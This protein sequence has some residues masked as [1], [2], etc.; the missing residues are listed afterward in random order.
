VDTIES[1]WVL[2][3][4]IRRWDTDESY[5]LIEV[6]SP[7]K[8]P[9]PPPHSHRHEREFFLILSGELDVMTDGTWQTLRAGSFVELPPNTVHTFI[10]NTAQD[11]AWVTGWRPKGFQKFFRDFGIPVDEAMARDRSVSAEMIQRVLASCEGY[12]MFLR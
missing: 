12:G 1:A 3:H 10:N 5:G 2:G 7:P 6:I 11:V 8:V 9:G 4:K